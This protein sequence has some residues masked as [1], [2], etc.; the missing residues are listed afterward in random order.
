MRVDDLTYL[1]PCVHLIHTLIVYVAYVKYMHMNEWKEYNTHVTTN[2][3][4][5]LLLKYVQYT[6][7]K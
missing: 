5:K 3:E 2:N 6:P 1:V 7:T 4:K